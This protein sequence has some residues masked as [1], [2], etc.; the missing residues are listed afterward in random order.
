LRGSA[1]NRRAA[2]L[3]DRGRCCNCEQPADHAHHVVPL[4]RGGRDT[5]GNLVS[6]CQECHE[7]VHGRSFG[8]NHRELTKAGMAAAKTRGAV[9]GAT[10]PD[11][12]VL[13]AV[14]A[15][16]A[17]TAAE[18]YRGLLAPMVA[19]GASLRAMAGALEAAGVQTT[20]G[21]S[22]WSAAQVQRVVKR[23]EA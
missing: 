8:T 7:L 15:D 19:A 1:I 17:T 18:R 10:R 3:R 2:L 23:L 11:V 16:Q 12:A 5:L 14:R 6:L 20:G 9:F 13:N 21:S 22:K 4:S